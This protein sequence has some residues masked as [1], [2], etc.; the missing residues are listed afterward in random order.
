MYHY[1]VH[2]GLWRFLHQQPTDTIIGS[3]KS[4][5]IEEA[6]VEPV[7]SCCLL[8]RSLYCHRCV[9]CISHFVKRLVSP[10]FPIAFAKPC[11]KKPPIHCDQDLGM[12]LLY[13]DLEACFSGDQLPGF[14]TDT[15]YRQGR[16][17]MEA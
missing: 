13:L 3:N 8:F 1:T 6:D 12:I 17:D 16:I 4:S 5:I 15:G 14:C 7:S 9:L 11:V 10:H 2:T